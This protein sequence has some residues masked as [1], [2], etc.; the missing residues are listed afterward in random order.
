MDDPDIATFLHR[1]TV[2]VRA[3]LALACTAFAAAFAA[4]P[5][6]AQPAADIVRVADSA[7]IPTAPP[8]GAPTPLFPPHQTSPTAPVKNAAAQPKKPPPAAAHPAPP[9][10]PAAAAPPHPPA[11]PPKLLIP[12]A[13]LAANFGTPP[14]PRPSL[15]LETALQPVE[16]PSEAPQ[17]N[18][19]TPASTKPK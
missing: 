5:A 19:A 6:A 12:P 2:W 3:A 7:V 16:A 10:H 11:G 1:R 15:P 14:S 8:I 18:A 17:A 13:T 4:G 9:A